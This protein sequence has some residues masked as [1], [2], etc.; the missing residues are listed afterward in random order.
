LKATSGQKLKASRKRPLNRHELEVSDD[1]NV[2]TSTRKLKQSEN[3]YDVE[4]DPAFGYRIIDFI[5]VFTVISNIIVCK[6]CK[7]ELKFTES[8]KRGLGF[9]IVVSCENCEKTEIPSCSFIDKG[10]EINRRIVLAMR[11]LGVGLHGIIKFCA[12]MELL[13]PIFHSFYDKIVKKISTVTDEVCKNSMMNAAKAE[14]AI[15]MEKGENG[16]TVSGDGSWRKV[17][18]PRCMT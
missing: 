16:I 6:E 12:F 10:Y 14:K 18:F 5:A 4:V 7:L 13:R 3:L 9:K 11:M 2:S 1:S 8:G 17:I 15:S